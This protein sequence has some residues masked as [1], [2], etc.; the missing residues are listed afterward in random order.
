MEGRALE[1]ALGMGA[2]GR[3]AFRVH[4]RDK[5]A[6]FELSSAPAKGHGA[7]SRCLP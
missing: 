2:V 5:S 6:F 7:G 4:Y 3:A 1:R